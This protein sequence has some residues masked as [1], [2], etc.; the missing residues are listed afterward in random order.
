MRLG[1]LVM[2]IGSDGFTPPLGAVGEITRLMDSYGDYEVYFPR[3]ICP[4]EP[5]NWECQAAWLL[6]ID[7]GDLWEYAETEAVA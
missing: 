3:H 1:Q 5:P 2:L 6:P 7:P 4:V